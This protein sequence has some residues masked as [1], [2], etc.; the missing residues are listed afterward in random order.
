MYLGF[1]VEVT[2]IIKSSSQF[3]Y[4][5]V[6]HINLIHQRSL[7][8]PEQNWERGIFIYSCIVFIKS[9]NAT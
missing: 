5:N 9:V 6:R 4:V 7:Q 8:P 1:G 3:M 2:R